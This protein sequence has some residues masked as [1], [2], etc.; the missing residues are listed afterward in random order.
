MQFSYSLRGL[1]SLEYSRIVRREYVDV[2]MQSTL[3]IL[4]FGGIT[5][6]VNAAPDNLAESMLIWVRYG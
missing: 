5:G 2:R 4:A 6:I 1:F 3:V